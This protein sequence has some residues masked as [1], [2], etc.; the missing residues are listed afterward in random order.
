MCRT[1]RRSRRH[2]LIA[3]NAKY[4]ADVL[5][6]LDTEGLH[7]ELTEPLRPGDIRPTDDDYLCVLMPCPLSQHSQTR[8]GGTRPPAHPHPV[9]VADYFLHQSQ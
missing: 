1:T 9:F 5:N 4:L 8:R 6:V 7:I 3:F 2:D